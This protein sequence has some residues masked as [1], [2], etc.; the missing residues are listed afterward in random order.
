MSDGK[1]NGYYINWDSDLSLNNW[2]IEF[3]LRC[4][5]DWMIG[6]FASSY[7]IGHVFGNL[8]VRFG[9]TIGRIKVISVT[10]NISI[11]IFA[12][13]VFV[14]RNI[15]LTYGLLFLLGFF[16]NVRSNLAF[17]YGQEI[18]GQKY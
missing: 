5:P 12:L 1:S 9:D 11:I 8:I 15:W 4:K 18:V 2:F 10:Q 6:M 17:I 7:F 3:D 13:I 16:S 14:S